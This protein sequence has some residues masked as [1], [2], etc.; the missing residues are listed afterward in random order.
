MN[1]LEELSSLRAADALALEKLFPLETLETAIEG[2]PPPP[3]FRE[4][5]SHKGCLNVIAELKKASPSKGLIRQDFHPAALAKELEKAGAAAL[6]CLC[7]PHRFLGSEEYLRAAA[8]SVAIP[9]LYK[10]FVTTRYQIAR[11]RVSGAAAVLL[12]AAVLDEAKLK[13][14]LDC[15][16]A[17]GLDALVETHT[18]GEVASALAAGARIVGVNCRDLKTFHTDPAITASLISQIP[19]TC[20]RVAESGMRSAED[21]RTL[22]AAG[23]NAFLIGETLMR[24][25]SP[26]AML[27]SMIA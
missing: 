21:L 16:H 22:S 19:A 5:V 24:S 7:E 13:E 15:A 17:Y 8:G 1:I 27:N 18:E 4:A 25:P 9:V 20:V 23:A 26:G 3:S 12:I 6:S 11:A 14:L 10:D 2:L